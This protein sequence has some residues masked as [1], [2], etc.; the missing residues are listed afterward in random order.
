[1][2]LFI[3]FFIALFLT[4]AHAAP[5]K[6]LSQISFFSFDREN[7]E[8]IRLEYENNKPQLFFSLNK[9]NTMNGV[10]FCRSARPEDCSSL[11]E[12]LGLNFSE[13]RDVQ[14]NMLL[15]V[16]ESQ[17]AY[18]KTLLESAASAKANITCQ[19]STKVLRLRPNEGYSHK[20][21][22]RVTPRFC[23]VEYSY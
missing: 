4:Q 18:Y 21:L 6:N 22:A 17:H 9:Q 14:I 16:P 15:D 23:E 8:S 1:M 7:I 2:Q 12:I 11:Q 3:K 10:E 19:G 5:P 13:I 20:L